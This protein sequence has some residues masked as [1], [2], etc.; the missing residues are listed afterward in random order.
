MDV[1]ED[2]GEGILYYLRILGH[3]F[4]EQ[5]GDEEA[6]EDE[7]GVDGEERTH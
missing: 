7:E 6:G 1:E 4:E 5:V 2:P 3:R